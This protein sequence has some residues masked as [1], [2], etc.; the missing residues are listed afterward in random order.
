MDAILACADSRVPP[1]IVFDQG[2][3]DIFVCRVAG[4]IATAEEI[5]S[6]EYAVLELNVKV[7]ANWR[8]VGFG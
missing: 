1:E 4:N 7:R 2:F 5:A 3:G 8:A 6:L